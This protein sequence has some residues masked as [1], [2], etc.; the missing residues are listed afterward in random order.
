MSAITY[1]ASAVSVAFGDEQQL[2]LASAR[3][4]QGLPRALA[5]LEGVG[6]VKRGRGAARSKVSD[7]GC[8]AGRQRRQ[9]H[10]GARWRREVFDV[11]NVLKDLC[12]RF[13]I[14]VN[15]VRNRC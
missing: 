9:R 15:S 6:R 14:G 5:A 1:S 4:G 2:H 3:P 12:E 8:V 10:V 13:E 11:M 7:R